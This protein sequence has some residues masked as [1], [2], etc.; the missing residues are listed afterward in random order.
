VDEDEPTGQMDSDVLRPAA[1]LLSLK[2]PRGVGDP[3]FQ[4]ADGW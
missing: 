3:R 4:R 2:P 1:L